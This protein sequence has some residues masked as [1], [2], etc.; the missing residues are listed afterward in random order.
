MCLSCYGRKSQSYGGKPSLRRHIVQVLFKY[1]SALQADRLENVM[2]LETSHAVIVHYRALLK[3]IDDKLAEPRQSDSPHPGKRRF[4][5]GEEGPVA[6]RKLMSR[7]RSFL[8][9]EEAFWAELVIRATKV[10]NLTQASAAITALSLAD[11][12]PAELTLKK[13]DSTRGS[14]NRVDSPTSES[15]PSATKEKKLLFIHKCLI[16]LGDL[17]R[18]REQFS[19]SGGRPKAGTESG[20]P[21]RSGSRRHGGGASSRTRDYSRASECYKQAKALIPSEGN[22]SNQL[23]ILALY[24][25]DNFNALMHYYHA[26]C[27]RNPFVTSRDNLK[28]CL[29]KALQAYRKGNDD[30]DQRENR[31]L[32]FQR[33]VVALHALWH[34]KP[35]FV[36]SRVSLGDAANIRLSVI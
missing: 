32:I 24:G 20:P 6:R 34:L 19:E 33:D 35:T 4:K 21:A 31:V 12:D 18:Y 22:P 8:S 11:V 7:F 9:Q 30:A 28:Q 17:S 14:A 2:W 36:F 23:A 25:G 10:F 27:A 5:N 1:P 3:A 16:S 29:E 26:L 13:M 15:V